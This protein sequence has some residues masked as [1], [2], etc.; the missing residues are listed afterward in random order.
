L[1]KE[2]PK[3]GLHAS[4]K[5]IL[6]RVTLRAWGGHVVHLVGYGGIINYELL[7]RNLTVTT[8]CYCQQLRCLEEAVQQKRPGRWHGVIFQHDN[9]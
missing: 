3:N 6:T 7:E 5:A 1:L 8:E 4:S 9:T 2:Q